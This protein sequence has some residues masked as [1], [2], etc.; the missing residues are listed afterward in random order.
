MLLSSETFQ[1]EVYNEDPILQLQMWSYTDVAKSVKDAKIPK[2]D[3]LQASKLPLDTLQQTLQRFSD[4]QSS[5][6]QYANAYVALI[7][8]S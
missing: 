1:K 3:E 2:F 8:L 4:D 7:A 6:S 5:Q